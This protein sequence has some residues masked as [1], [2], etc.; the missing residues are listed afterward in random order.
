MTS[1]LDYRHVLREELVARC[2]RNPNYSARAM[3]RDLDVSPGFFSQ[4]MS[5]ARELSEQRALVLAERAKWNARK[6]NVFVKLVRLH[7]TTDPRIRREVLADIKKTT[8]KS[9]V[10]LKRK[11][12]DLPHDEFKLI[13][14]WYHFAIVELSAISEL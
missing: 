6:R 12:H 1:N 3:A 11:F 2:S 8:K 5:G 7:G 9:P 4:I 14:E 13:C 10:A